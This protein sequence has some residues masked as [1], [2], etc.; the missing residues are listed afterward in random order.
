VLIIIELSIRIVYLL[1]AENVSSSDNPGGWN[2]KKMTRRSLA[3]QVGA[4]A[5]VTAGAVNLNPRA[6]GAN[7]PITLALVGGNNRGWQIAEPLIQEALF[8][9][10]NLNTAVRKE[11]A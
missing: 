1:K 5:A 4:P 9:S 10:E 8:S 2:M 11:N 6:L 7:D 3:K